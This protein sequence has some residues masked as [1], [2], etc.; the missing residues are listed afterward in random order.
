MKTTL[1]LLIILLTVSLFTSA[2][3]IISSTSTD[4]DSD[5]DIVIE[6]FDSEFAKLTDDEKL[7]K[8]QDDTGIF[9]EDPDE[10][11]EQK[12]GLARIQSGYGKNLA[13]YP[14]IHEF[15]MN[16]GWDYEGLE[17]LFIGDKPELLELDGK[18]NVIK[19]HDIRD[20]TL[21]QL[22]EK[23]IELGVKPKK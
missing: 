20:W 10:E 7:Q 2:K 19:R 5:D 1:S 9:F 3:F 4:T 17:V 6:E 21:P 23:L 16:E 12:S 13:K 14:Q 8:I 15:V 22:R 18:S 11:V